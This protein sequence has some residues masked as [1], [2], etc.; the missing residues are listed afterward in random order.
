M[1]AT[2]GSCAPEFLSSTFGMPHL[3]S[4]PVLLSSTAAGV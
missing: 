2:P 1:L 3:M 4:G